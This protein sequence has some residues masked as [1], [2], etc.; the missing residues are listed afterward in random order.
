MATVT[1]TQVWFHNRSDLSDYV[2]LDATQL[3]DQTASPGQVRRFAGGRLRSI[4]TTGNH[5]QLSITFEL[6]DRDTVDQLRDWTG[7]TLLY[8]DP[9]G[10]N[11]FGVF[12]E[13]WILE[14]PTTGVD[15]V[16]QVSLTFEEITDTVEV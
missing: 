9:L 6:V 12:H 5:R 7:V 11:L 3:W 4:T 15:S 2:T 14:L 13:P 10:R 8:R 1:L 16:Y